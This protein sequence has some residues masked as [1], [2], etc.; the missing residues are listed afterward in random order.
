MSKVACCLPLIKTPPCLPT[1]KIEEIYSNLKMALYEFEMHK[2]EKRKKNGL[3]GTDE[4]T[5][6]DMVKLSQD[7][8][9]KVYELQLKH[10]FKISDLTIHA[11]H[12]FLRRILEADI[13]PNFITSYF[14]F[15][16]NYITW[17]II[18]SP[19]D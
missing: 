9:N 15:E 12:D 19:R 16:K 14:N 1:E 5:N 4:Y 18:V 11:F 6:R 7:M 17:S 13:S 8:F 2:C 10:H 3:G